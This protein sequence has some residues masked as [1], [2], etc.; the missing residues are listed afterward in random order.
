MAWPEKEKTRIFV[1]C[2]TNNAVD[3]LTIGIYSASN[4]GKNP[5]PVESQFYDF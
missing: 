3:H 5:S 4:E 1:W 2:L